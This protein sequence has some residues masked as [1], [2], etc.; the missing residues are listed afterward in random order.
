VDAQRPH[1]P[2]AASQALAALALGVGLACL[3]LAAY[4]PHG[5]R[6]L[7][8]PFDMASDAY[9]AAHLVEF[10]SPSAFPPYALLAYWLLL[11]ASSA[12]L[13]ARARRLHALHLAL[14]LAFALLSLRHVRLAYTFAIVATPS[15]ALAI[16]PLLAR[17]RL[18]LRAVAIAGL[19]AALLLQQKELAPPGLGLAARTFPNALFDQL[20][21]LAL[22]GPAF[23]SDAWAGPLLGRYYPA[24]KSFFDNRFEAYP[25]AFFRDVYQCIRNGEPGWDRLLDRYGVEIA[26][27]R[28][29]TPG[30]AALQGNHPNLRQRLVADPRWSL[31]TFDDQGELFVRSAGVNSGIATRHALH[32]IDPDRGLFLAQ[33]RSQLNALSAELARGNHSLRVRAF[34]A[35]AA[36]DAGDPTAARALERELA[37]GS[38]SL[39]LYGQ[40]RAQLVRSTR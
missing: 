3:S 39:A 1:G 12:A 30:E 27:L 22:K 24:R 7:L 21:A 38:D 28:Y 29:T 9:L 25:R 32:G 15:L 23:V 40:L 33:P 35:V 2:R 13:L 20:D 6:A 5:A 37:A 10:R 18:P 36:L 17:L 14:V 34:A 4:H 26:L 31:L 8:F 16:T 19:S 11:A